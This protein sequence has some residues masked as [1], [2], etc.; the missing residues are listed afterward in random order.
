MSYYNPETPG[1]DYQQVIWWEYDAAD[2]SDNSIVT[3]RVTG[4]PSPTGWAFYRLC[5]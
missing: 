2:Y 5:I 4:G 1:D 3:I